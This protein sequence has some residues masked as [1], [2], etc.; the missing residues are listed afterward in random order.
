MSSNLSAA[1]VGPLLHSSP[2]STR[3]M[4]RYWLA[5]GAVF[6]IAVVLRIHQLHEVSAWYDE[7]AS[8]KTIQFSWS[9]M[10]Q[11]IQMNVHP[12]VY[13]VILKLWA[14]VFGY[15]PDSLRVF[16]VLCGVITVGVV[17]W[18]VRE[19]TDEES[20]PSRAKWFALLAAALYAINPI[21]IEQ[22]QQA[23]MYTLGIL[24]AALLGWGTLRVLKSPLQWS[25][26][27]L[28]ILFGN[29]LPLTHYYG[30]FTS[31]V[32]AIVIGVRM[33][34]V[35][36]E[37]SPEVRNAAWARFGTAIAVTLPV[38]LFWGPVFW[39]QHSRVQAAYWIQ[40]FTWSEPIVFGAEWVSSPWIRDWGWFFS[41]QLFVI[42]I[43]GTVFI[44]LSARPARWVLAGFAL[45][46]PLLST[47]YSLASRNLLQGRYWSFAHLFF[48]VGLVVVVAGLS[49]IGVRRGLAGM[50]IAW[51]LFWVVQDRGHRNLMAEQWGLRGAGETLKIVRLPGEPVLVASPY[52]HPSMQWYQDSPDRIYVPAL[53]PFYSNNFPGEAILRKHE[54]LP[55][56]ATMT[57]NSPRLWIMVDSFHNHQIDDPAKFP[58]PAEWH[59]GK[60]FKFFEGNRL[61]AS[62][63]LREYVRH[64][65]TPPPV[66][67]TRPA[68]D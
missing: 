36:Q 45:A 53:G 39:A 50:L 9:E 48:L 52:Y 25:G 19:A 66:P 11:S 47:L 27:V 55:L 43:A 31:L 26:W 12:P 34:A 13:Y 41:V 28:V 40:P 61:P 51:S 20:E 60:T 56:D 64:W 6:V 24:F 23:R 42:G 29:L 1:T 44:A 32:A 54:V 57:G 18:L 14:G 2:E 22:S 4:W 16:S 15:S 21:A 62:L 49:H 59:L 17:G 7:A 63:E 30:L 58:L 68:G 46:P 5:W 10:F 65:P 8:W 3:Q 37:T 67:L 38:W 33:G 35:W